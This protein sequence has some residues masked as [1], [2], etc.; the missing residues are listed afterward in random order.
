MGTVYLA[1]QQDLNRQV[2][3]KVLPDQFPGHD[4]T[5]S[6]RFLREAGICARLSHPNIVK[7][8]DYGHE[9]GCY[10][11][12]MERLQ[13]RDLKDELIG[14]PIPKLP[15]TLSLARQVV[16]AF[17]HYH[18]QGIVHRDLKPANIMI[19]ESGSA[20]LT[21][22]GLVK[23]LM[24]T[25]ITRPN[26]VVGTPYYLAPEMVRA[27]PVTAAA[28]I[29]QL[30]V[31]LYLMLTG[32]LPFEGKTSPEV[33]KKVIRENPPSPRQIN[34]DV[35]R[36]L[37]AMVMN[38]LAKDL[39]IRYS[40]A[41]EL[42]VEL[43]EA[44]RWGAVERRDGLGDSSKLQTP[45]S[46]RSGSGKTEASGGRPRA[47]SDGDD[48]G[49]LPSRQSKPS[50][51]SD[52]VAVATGE[53]QRGSLLL[54]LGLMALFGLAGLAVGVMFLRPGSTPE[55]R[56]AD[57]TVESTVPDVRRDAE[58]VP[59]NA[60][61]REITAEQVADRLRIAAAV[62]R[63]QVLDKELRDVHYDL[64]A[65]TARM[66]KETRRMAQHPAA[67]ALLEVP[68]EQFRPLSKQMSWEVRAPIM[69]SIHSCLLYEFCFGFRGEKSPLD[70][71]RRLAPV[72]RI[73]ETPHGNIKLNSADLPRL[74]A[75]AFPDALSVAP[76]VVNRSKNDTYAFAHGR[77]HALPS[78]LE[79]MLGT[80]DDVREMHETRPFVVQEG[81]SIALAG[82]VYHVD[83]Q[84][85]FLLECWPRANP[86][87]TPVQI[88][89]V[90]QVSELPGDWAL[91]GI[92]LAPDVLPSGEYSCRL[93]A[94]QFLEY[95]GGRPNLRAL[96]AVTLPAF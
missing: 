54:A 21:D 47:R 19:V 57:S 63:T 66:E 96:Y 80:K 18:P 45:G 25:D 92:Q 65:R 59:S 13:G 5:L 6:K 93:S 74:V 84:V 42:E 3:L 22:F 72:L 58:P 91:V 37:D 86:E 81:K 60:E 48:S 8:Y 67:R 23:D 64:P 9:K 29:Y 83:N 95:I 35:P 20:V 41:E 82:I 36:G 15:R 11:Y 31:I 4:S 24:A 52:T 90:R 79:E 1:V 62:L 38:C 39:S 71:N 55:A 61:R 27:L 77:K 33:M 17:K 12:T 10:Y 30:G 40:S 76:L 34:S 73:L 51:V 44:A 7:V 50:A 88:P 46:S 68:E 75:R 49:K 78:G 69:A 89:L 28:D 43:D 70:L 2:A 26:V 85:G 14:S 53:V 16:D 32:R 94:H 56:I 87:L